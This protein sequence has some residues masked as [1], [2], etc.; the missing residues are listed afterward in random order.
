[1][2]NQSAS[3]SPRAF[4]GAPGEASVRNLPVNLFASVIGLSGVSAA[5]RL[6]HESLGAPHWI[7]EAVGAFAAGVFVLLAAAYLC[8]VFKYPSSVRAEFHH[9]VAGN[10]FGT[11]AISLLLL[12]AVIWPYSAPAAQGIW[13]AGVL[14]TFALGFVVISRLLQ[15]QV[16]A[17]HAVPAWLVPG[18]ATLDIPVT[19]AQ[20]PMAWANELNLFA[21]A[22]GAVL[23]V[24]LF[25][26]IVSRL[27][28]HHP[29]TPVMTPSLMILV[30]PFSVGF[31]AYC[32]ITGGIDRFAAVLFYF[33]LFMFTVVAPK[34]FRPSVGFSS[35]WWAIG[36]PVAALANAALKYAQFRGT[37]LHWA[38]AIALLSGLSLAAGVLTV[39]T[40][41]S[42]FTKELF[43]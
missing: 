16:E 3:P 19:G 1:M 4:S 10:F 29:L 6:A 11:I 17:S 7:G 28:H 31:L 2:Q 39:R 13:I 24:V 41:H 42:G 5:W 21:G 9:P 35:G 18:V 38:L 32:N 8:K 43:K 40:V 30:A 12:S 15:G 33:A 34:V 14:A 27:V 37:G 22:I 26:M 36:F 20:M 25:A 23:A